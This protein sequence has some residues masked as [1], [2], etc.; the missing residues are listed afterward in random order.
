MENRPSLLVLLPT[1]LV[2]DAED[3]QQKTAKIGVVGR[4]LAIFCVRKV[5]IYDDFDPHVKNQERESLLIS[6]LLRYMETPQY[7]RKLLF[8]HM[9]ELTKAGVLPPLRTPHHP[10]ACE[11]MSRGDVREGVVVEAFEDHSL[12]EIGLKK[13]ARL[14]AKLPLKT[15]CSVRIIGKTKK[16]FLVEQ[17]SRDEIPEYWG[18]EVIRAKNLKAGLR[19]LKADYALGTS[20]FGNDL[21]PAIE[22]IKK[23]GTRTIAVAFGGPY[24]GLHEI[25]R[26]QGINPEKTF[27]G[28]VNTIKG[29]GTSTV[30]TEEALLATLALLNDHLRG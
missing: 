17:V 9:A 30:R 7:L 28:M 18:Y 3:L 13:M 5:C 15:R 16:H 29:Q 14:Q 12:L 24:A 19:L 23:R 22:M 2:S 25:C 11:R 26:R 8:P 20:K 27:D 10:S 21:K 4:A 6:T 1:S